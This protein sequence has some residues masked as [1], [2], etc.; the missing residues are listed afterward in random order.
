[1]ENKKHC[2]KCNSILDD[3]EIEIC[4]S[5]KNENKEYKHLETER[6]CLFDEIAQ[7]TKVLPQKQ[8]DELN[9]KIL[10][11]IDTEIDLEKHC[12]Q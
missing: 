3:F 11:L 8:I 6:D 12:N 7:I 4:N 1:M 5:C 10:A 9:C 2:K